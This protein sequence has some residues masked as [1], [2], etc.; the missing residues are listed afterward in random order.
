MEA[1]ICTKLLQILVA[2]L[3]IAAPRGTT[4]SQQLV[5]GYASGGIDPLNG[6]RLV[7]KRTCVTHGQTWKRASAQ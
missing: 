5:N 6:C 4:Q 7:V 3:F 2:A 1:S